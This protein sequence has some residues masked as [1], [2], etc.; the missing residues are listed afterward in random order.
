MNVVTPQ[1]KGMPVIGAFRV[2]TL[3]CGRACPFG[4]SVAQ[5]W[6]GT[7]WDP[8]L[9]AAVPPK[10]RCS[11]EE[12]APPRIEEPAPPRTESSWWVFFLGVGVVVACVATW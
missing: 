6:D 12:P 10:H 5:R 11:G 9:A 1:F 8:P 3:P 4:Y 2:L 7:K